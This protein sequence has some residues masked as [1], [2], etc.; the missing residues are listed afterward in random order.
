MSD[1]FTDLIPAENNSGATASPQT[2]TAENTSSPVSDPFNDL[3][4]QQTSDSGSFGALVD[5]WNRQFE[6]T[7]IGAM[8]LGSYLLPGTSGFRDKLSQLNAQGNGGT[9]VGEAQADRSFNEHPYAYGLGAIGGTIG[10]AVATGAPLAKGV[11]T[12]LPKLAPSVATSIGKFSADTLGPLGTKVLQ[13]MGAGAGYGSIMPANSLS[14][15]GINAALGSVL[16]GLTNSIIPAIKSFSSSDYK[17]SLWTRVFN[18][19]KAAI[20][21]TAANMN[22]KLSTVNPNNVIGEPI[23][24]TPENVNTLEELL[25]PFDELNMSPLPGQAIGSSKL[26]S[27]ENKAAE[28][29][30]L[31]G[32]E[33]IGFAQQEEVNKLQNHL[34]NTIKNM[35]PEETQATVEQLYSKMDE[36][37][38]TGPEI[39]TLTTNTMVS[40]YLR[41]LDGVNSPLASLPDT[42]VAKLDYVKQSIGKRLWNDKHAI[43]PSNT[44]PKEI[45][46]S[47]TNTYE[48]I[49]KTLSTAHPELYPVATAAAQKVSIQENYLDLVQK[50]RNSPGSNLNLPKDTKLTPEQLNGYGELNKINTAL[51]GDDNKIQA[52]LDDIKTVGGDIDTAKAIVEVSNKMAGVNVDKVLAQHTGGLKELAN[53]GSKEGLIRNFMS[54]LFDTRY[55]KALLNLATSGDK[56]RPLIK[57]EIINQTTNKEDGFMRLILKASKEPVKGAINAQIGAYAGSLI[58]PQ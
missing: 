36:L 11:S 38:V 7:A 13:G 31:A 52:F 44:L 3:V 53:A 10:S 49:N 16:G 41:K 51:F 54:T 42:S 14:E 25:E 18:P 20:Q 28:S 9:I 56:W 22:T 57:K 17:S 37:S 35:A 1:P 6:K 39:E 55:E 24:N 32:S 30:G 29:T 45:K 27:L 43:D 58:F 21:D 34:A 50:V 4:P 47:L 19:K 15:H 8:Q 23:K 26:T 12:V 5:G 46:D 48:Q 40:E 2:A 33:K